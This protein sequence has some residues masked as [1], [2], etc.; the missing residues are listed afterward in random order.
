MIGTKFASYIRY[1]TKT[2]SDTL[3]D[4]DLVLLANV[5]K[6]DLA[7]YIANEVGEDYFQ[8]SYKRNLI[9]DQREYTLPEPLMGQLKR[10]SVMLDGENWNEPL[11]EL[12]MNQVRYALITE[13]DIQSAFAGQKPA[14]DFLD[15]G[16]KIYSEE[17]ITAVTAGLQVE[18]IIYP[19]DLT[20]GSLALST[21][22]SVPT[23]TV[24]T[25]MPKAAHKVW[26][27]MTSIA[28]KESRPKKIPLTLEEKNIEVYKQI[29]INK[30]RGRNLD[31][32]YVSAAPSDTGMN[33]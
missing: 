7:E 8:L 15:R 18:A 19:A 22:L 29:M 17:A 5:E 12:D 28:Y 32:S 14:Y 4:A 16:I 1:K 33:Y 6:D 9:A 21:D 27:L 13:A 23:S 31:R 3:P 10:V 26:A 25:A 24:T 30:L 2:N 11:D 20:T